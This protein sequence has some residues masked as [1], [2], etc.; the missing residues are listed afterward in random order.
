M[1]PL[2]EDD[3]ENLRTL[4]ASVPNLGISEDD[5]PA[6]L[7]A[8]LARN[9]TTCLGAFVGDRLAGC[10]LGGY[11]GRRGYLYHLAVHPDYQ[12]N[13]YGRA[14]LRA[15]AAAFAVLGV[16]KIRLVV[17]GRNDQ[18]RGFYQHLGWVERDD[19]VVVALNQ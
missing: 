3:L 8:F 4:W 9:P 17:F 7:A 11:D 1:R 6:P 2:R 10:V 5:E 15:V 13:G 18:A 19:L 16:K 12:G 14:L